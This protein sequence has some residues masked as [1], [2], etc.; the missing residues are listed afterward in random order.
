MGE[1]GTDRRWEK[2]TIFHQYLSQAFPRVSVALSIRALSPTE[3]SCF[4]VYCSHESSQL[5]KINT[6]GL[7]YVWEGS[8]K[9]LKPILLNAHQGAYR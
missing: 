1:V 7:L 4:L 2:F 3:Y 6:Y 9:S 5:T 8:K